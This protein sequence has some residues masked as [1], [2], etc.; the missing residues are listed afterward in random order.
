MLFLP[1]YSPD[2]N[3][4]ERDVA[5]LKNY[6]SSSSPRPTHRLKPLAVLSLA[7]EMQGTVVILDEG[8]SRHE[9]NGGA[10]HPKKTQRPSPDF[11]IGYAALLVH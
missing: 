7:L 6:D 10:V 3:P 11:Q 8:L 4:I 2:L 5:N 1:T 9:A